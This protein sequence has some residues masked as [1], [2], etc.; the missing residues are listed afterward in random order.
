LEQVE[1][2]DNRGEPYFVDVLLLD[3]AL[4]LPS[5]SNPL[6]SHLEILER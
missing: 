4:T 1:G 6:L 3:H 5:S 2:D